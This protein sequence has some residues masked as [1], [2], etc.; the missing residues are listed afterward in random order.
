MD[1]TFQVALATLSVNEQ[2]F[3]LSFALLID[4]LDFIYLCT[5]ASLVN[6]L[7]VCL[8]LYCYAAYDA[9]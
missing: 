4:P 7:W 9:L 2:A 1:G 3:A 5:Q 6:F 8:L